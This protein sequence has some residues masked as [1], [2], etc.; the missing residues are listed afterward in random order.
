MV[1]NIKNN[2]ISETD[3]K[4]RLNALN[5]KKSL[6]I[7]HKRLIPGQKELSN[8][9]DDLTDTILTNKTLMSSKEENETLKQ[10]KENEK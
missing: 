2:I 1:N 9:F 4:K 8:L 7:K 5:T 3:A 6:E 10:E